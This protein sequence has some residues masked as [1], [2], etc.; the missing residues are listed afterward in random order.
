M[1]TH[2]EALDLLKKHGIEGFVLK[3]VLRVN[4]IAV[5]LAKKLKEKGE[6]VN[7]E[8]TDI[9]SLL[10]DIGKKLADSTPMNHIDAGVKILNDEGMKEIGEVIKK[11]SIN[12]IVEEDKIPTTWEEK[13]IFYAD[14]R[15]IEDKIASLDERITDLK[16]RYPDIEKFL[17][18]AVPKIKKLEETIFNILDISKDLTELKND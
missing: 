17:G 4:Q 5:Y 2:E 7:V 16:T 1:I 3:H 15:V 9:A 10:H 11:H 8:L 6:S 14:R 12:A 13:L 18:E